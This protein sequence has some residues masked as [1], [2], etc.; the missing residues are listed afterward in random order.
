MYTSSDQLGANPKDMKA[1][2]LDLRKRSKDIVNAL[3]RN[4]SVTLFYRGKA[5]GVIVPAS[6]PPHKAASVAGHRAFGM[7]RDRAE[8]KS[9]RRIVAELRKARHAL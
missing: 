3:D 6:R 7:W 8:M 2:F 5:K 4:Q 1:T 9:V